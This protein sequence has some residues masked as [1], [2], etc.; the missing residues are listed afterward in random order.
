[1]DVKLIAKC[2]EHGVKFATTAIIRPKSFIECES[3]VRLDCD[4]YMKGFIGAYSYVRHGS[5]L[6]S[7]QWIGRYCSIATNVVIGAGEHPTNWLSTHP[8]QHG[9]SAVV[10]RRAEVD[11]FRYLKPP[12]P[13][14]GVG[15]GHDVWIGTGA[16]IKRGVTVG[17]GAVV[18]AGAVVTKDVPPYAIVGG[19]PAKIIRYRFSHE[20]INRMLRV[21]WWDYTAES[22][23][24]VNFSD[25]EQA[26]DDV[27]SFVAKGIAKRLPGKT[28]RVTGKGDFKVFE[29]KT[30][31]A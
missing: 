21:G 30:G 1:M 20:I 28:V 13:P 31:P 22:L 2:A 8:F 29:P 15:I 26:L 5:I 3:P 23:L 25:A 11:G 24:G 17:N 6:T 4:I 27:E 9:N 7:V 14:P 18:G 10:R 16:V 12:E 19:V